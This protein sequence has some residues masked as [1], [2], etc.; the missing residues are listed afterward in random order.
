[1]VKRML[2]V[3]TALRSLRARGAVGVSG[4]VLRGEFRV[5]FPCRVVG[6]TGMLRGALRRMYHLSTHQV[7]RA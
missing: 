3:V 1:M 5:Y 6:R 4:N 2:L 7:A